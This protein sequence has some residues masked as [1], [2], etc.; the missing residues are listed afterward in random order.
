LADDSERENGI[1]PMPL[2]RLRALARAQNRHHRAAS[3]RIFYKLSLALP[4]CKMGS[5]FTLSAM[6]ILRNARI[7]CTSALVR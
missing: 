5:D 3:A 6:P 1:E 2:S 4:Y 7:C